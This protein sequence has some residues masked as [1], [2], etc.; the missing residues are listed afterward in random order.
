MLKII[1]L[2]DV[3]GRLGR[4]AIKKEIRSLK[5][6]Y[7]PDLIIANTENIAHGKGVSEKT[8]NE[9]QSSGVNFFT[10]GDHSFDAISQIET[11]YNGQFPIIRPAN[12]SK[13]VPGKGF[14]IISTKKGDVLIINLIGRVF[15]KM[16]Y[17]CPFDAVDNI[18]ANFA[19]QKLSAIIVDIHAEASS[20][21]IALKHYVNNR[22]SVIVGTHTHVQTADQEISK[23]TASITDLGMCGFKEG[24]L[25]LEKNSI[26]KTFCDQIK[27]QPKLP[28]KGKAVIS[29]VYV[30]IDPKNKRA[31]KIELINKK[32]I[33]K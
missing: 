19:K 11:C 8:L 20:E 7:Q 10:G 33:I 25:G 15:M 18:L 29:G 12:Y 2:G 6:Q 24:C 1:F 17:N 13:K 30:E 21:K 26:I 28:E 5:K 16:D 9:L 14:D 32:T 31:K 4:K 22:V 23:G 3:V 27:R